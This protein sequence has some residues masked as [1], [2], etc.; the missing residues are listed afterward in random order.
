MCW[1]IWPGAVA[2]RQARCA[3]SDFPLG[4]GQHGTH[5]SRRYT[6]QEFTNRTRHLGYRRLDVGRNRRERIHSHYSCG[7]R[8]RDQFDRHRAHLRLRAL[9][10]PEF[11]A[12]G[13]R[14]NP[15]NGVACYTTSLSHLDRGSPFAC[16]SPGEINTANA[17]RAGIAAWPR[18]CPS[19]RKVR[20]M[21]RG[22]ESVVA[23]PR[24]QTISDRKPLPDPCGRFALTP[25]FINA[26]SASGCKSVRCPRQVQY[27]RQHKTTIM[28][29][30]PTARKVWPIFWSSSSKSH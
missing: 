15:P 6:S 27:P 16:Q 9:R 24:W 20:P 21:P 11:M 25:T 2:S 8:S 14:A 29:T 3:A 1:K 30:Q 22:D 19:T 7:A 5:Q 13:G 26:Q 17:I 23:P 10:N 12:P 4:E 28:P 18:P